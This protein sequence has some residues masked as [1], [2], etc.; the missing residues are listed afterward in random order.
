MSAS[1]IRIKDSRLVFV[2]SLAILVVI[3]SS[4]GYGW[5]VSEEARTGGM[6]EKWEMP[7]R[8]TYQT[9]LSAIQPDGAM[10]FTDSEQHLISLI[11]RDG[12]IEW[13]HKYE[14]N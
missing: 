12:T 6:G 4:F 2:S 13:S 8:G 3:V 14:A 10:L 9:D 7:V 5:I 11:D 1:G